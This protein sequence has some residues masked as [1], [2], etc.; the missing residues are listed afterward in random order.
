MT[1]AVIQLKAAM[2]ANTSVTQS[3]VTLVQNMA[4]QMLDSQDIAELH[5]MATQLQSNTAAIAAAVT[6][7]TVA[8]GEPPATETPPTA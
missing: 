3:V 5:A 4:Q 6:A 8:A 7:N 1:D 2:E